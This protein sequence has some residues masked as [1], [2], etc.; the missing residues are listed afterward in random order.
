MNWSF[1]L[2][3][4]ER[5]E[6]YYK[7]LLF[8][9]I[10]NTAVNNIVWNGLPET[11]ESRYIEKALFFDGQVALFK[12]ES[13]DT[14]FALPITTQDDLNSYFEPQRWTARGYN[15][16]KELNYWNSVRIRNN[17]LSS[18]TVIDVIYYIDKIAE[19]QQTIN[20]NLKAHKK[21]LIFS[22]DKKSKLNIENAVKKIDDGSP[23]LYLGE[24]LKAALSGSSAIPSNIPYIIDK[25]YDYK[26]SLE[27]E[28]LTMFDI[29]STNTEKESGMTLFEASANHDYSVNG[30][31]SAMLTMREEA[32]E[33]INQLFPELNVNVEL[34]RRKDDEY[35]L[36]APRVYN[37]ASS[38]TSNRY[39]KYRTNV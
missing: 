18:P 31:I 3:K 35:L 7:N 23:Y 26:K 22:T 25:L 1:W 16:T 39:N 15:T 9:Q 32:C 24:D 4:P 14:F 5:L 12:D 2:N 19:V 11:V 37:D 36:G 29:N 21:P 27:N 8:R 17:L 13:K 20:V 10:Y 33:R 30:Y 28:L 34:R 6:L 38:V